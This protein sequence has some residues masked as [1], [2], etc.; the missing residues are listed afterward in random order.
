MVFS[1]TM[2]T[3]R[4]RLLMYKWTITIMDDGRVHPSAKIPPSRVNNLRWSILMD[5]WNLDKK[6]HLVSDSHCNTKKSTIPNSTYKE[7]ETMLGS[8]HVVLVAL[9]RGLRLVLSETIRIGD[10]KHHIFSMMIETPVPIQ[11][12][13][14]E[15]SVRSYCQ[16]TRCP[17]YSA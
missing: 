3:F 9:H 15:W 16:T 2:V 11:R 13:R 7:W 1:V 4:M 8:S 12:G 14:R 17:P 10:T 6:N 5:D